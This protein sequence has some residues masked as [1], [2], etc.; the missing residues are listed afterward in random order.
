MHSW[1]PG[2]GSSVFLYYFPS[3]VL[4]VGLWIQ[5]DWPASRGSAH[6]RALTIGAPG[7]SCVE[8]AK[9][10]NSGFHDCIASTLPTK[11]SHNIF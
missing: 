3:H 7:I 8:G 2:L 9:G 5:R 1:E 6:P 4:R 10:Q 11:S